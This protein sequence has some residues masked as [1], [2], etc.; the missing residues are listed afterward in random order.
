LISSLAIIFLYYGRAAK[1]GDPLLY[2]TWVVIIEHFWCIAYMLELSIFN[3]R[4]AYGFMARNLELAFKQ[5]WVGIV[6]KEMGR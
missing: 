4:E 1:G 3:R 5:G 2:E 6:S